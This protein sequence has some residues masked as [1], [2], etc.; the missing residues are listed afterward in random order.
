METARAV[1]AFVGGP[2]YK[3]LRRRSVA[4]IFVS[5]PVGAVND[6]PE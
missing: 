5:G 1:A 3:V 2:S 4:E 6:V